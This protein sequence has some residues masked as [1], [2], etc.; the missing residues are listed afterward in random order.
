MQCRSHPTVDRRDRCPSPLVSVVIPAYNGAAFI[1][2]ALESVLAQTRLPQE[3]VV[4]DDCSSDGTGAIV[5]ECARDAAVPIRWIPLKR[6][7]GGPAEPLNVGIRAARGAFVALL[8]QDDRMPPL[9][10]QR[11]LDAADTEEAWSLI[12]GRVAFFGDPSPAW[13]DPRTQ[14]EYLPSLQTCQGQVHRVSR[15]EGLRSLLQRNF[16][17]SNSNVFFRKELW[18]E[19]GG[20]EPRYRVCAD[21]AFNLRAVAAAPVLIVPDTLCEYR[22]RPDSLYRSANHRAFLEARELRLRAAVRFLPETTEDF[23]E[24]YWTTRQLAVARAKRRDVRFAWSLGRLLVQSGALGAHLR[25]RLSRR[26]RAVPTDVE[27]CP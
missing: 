20:F 11:C 25:F 27:G 8:E 18:Q 5:A 17:V 14:F 15:M 10:L 7:S 4:V 2:E 16:V 3:V 24:L 21:F 13:Q 22:C 26:F 1:R 19:I 12:I 23:W 6:N 9:R